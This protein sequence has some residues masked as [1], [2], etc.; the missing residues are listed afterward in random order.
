MTA[1]LQPNANKRIETLKSLS[2][3]RWAAHADTTQALCGNYANIQDSLKSIADDI[4]QNVPTRNEARSIYKKMDKLEIAFLS[5]LWH[6]ILQCFESASVALQAVNLDLCNAVDL[7]RS[8]RGYIASLHDQFDTFETQAKTMSPTVS[9]VY[10]EDTQR[11]RKRKVFLGESTTPDV[12]LSAREKF[13]A[14]VFLVVMDRVLAVI[15]CRFESYN[16]LNNTFGILN[17]IPSLSVQDLCKRA[18]DLQSRYSADLELDFVEEIVHFREFVSG[19]D[20]SF[21]TELLCF[22]REKNLQVIFPN[23]SIAL[24]LY[25]ILPVTNTSGER[26]FSK[27]KLVKNRLRSTVGQ[28]R[29]NH[30]TLMSLES[31]L[32][33]KL[34]FSD[35]IKDF[36]AKKSRR[37]KL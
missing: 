37:A 1:G 5:K 9:Q 14:T 32:V 21:A 16:D 33:Q 12:G 29:L 15:D 7:V 34:D 4:N 23:V 17:N 36:A 35:L 25:L 27:L 22:L 11:Q 19:K 18:S 2:N 6:C 20:N 30:L 24:R 31:D 3:T 13:S 26:S 8:L 10:K 28:D